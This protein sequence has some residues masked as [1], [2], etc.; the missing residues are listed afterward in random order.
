MLTS[1][2]DA[3]GITT[4]VGTL[5]PVAGQTTYWIE[6]YANAELSAKGGLSE[7]QWFLG[8]QQFTVNADHLVDISYTAPTPSGLAGESTSPTG[9]VLDHLITAIAIDENGNTS[10]FSAA[11]DVLRDAVAN[12]SKQLNPQSPQA[13]KAAVAIHKYEASSKP[14]NIEAVFQPNKILGTVPTIDQAAAY[15]GVGHFNWLQ[16]VTLSVPTYLLTISPQGTIPIQIGTVT[17]YYSAATTPLTYPLLDP[18]MN[19]PTQVYGINLGANHWADIVYGSATSTDALPYYMNDTNNTSDPFSYASFQAQLAKAG[20]SSFTP[21]TMWGFYDSPSVVQGVPAAGPATFNTALAGVPLLDPGTPVQWVGLDTGF[22][23]VTSMNK[24]NVSQSTFSNYLNQTVGRATATSG[25]PSATPLSPS[26]SGSTAAIIGGPA[27]RSTPAAIDGA[28]PA[29]ASAPPALTI[30]PSTIQSNGGGQGDL[31]N[32]DSLFAIGAAESSPPWTDAAD[33]TDL[34]GLSPNLSHKIRA[35]FQ[36]SLVSLRT[37][38][39]DN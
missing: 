34:S 26:F 4:I 10:E 5:Q 30:P 39:F 32:R 17:N 35:R 3:G 6:F 7:G 14:A 20:G 24:S 18:I 16:Y 1:V 13:Y 23:W 15:C 36:E 8:A 22:A 9:P 28:L 21:A 38:R 12:N 31:A 25:A 29:L 27:S 37:N 19:F 33:Q 11:R 2:T